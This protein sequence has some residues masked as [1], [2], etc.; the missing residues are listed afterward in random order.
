MSLNTE[1]MRFAVSLVEMVVI[2]VVPQMGG[3]YLFSRLYM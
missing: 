1:K 3:F 2:Y